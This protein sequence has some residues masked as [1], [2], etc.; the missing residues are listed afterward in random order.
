MLIILVTTIV[1]GSVSAQNEKNN[2]N[3]TEKWNDNVF[4]SVGASATMGLRD[5][6][7]GNGFW[8]AENPAFNV[9]LGKYINPLWSYRVQANGSWRKCI[10]GL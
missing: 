10:L 6:N 9:A 3:Y 1:V 7:Y 4:V 5:A 2:S 8:R